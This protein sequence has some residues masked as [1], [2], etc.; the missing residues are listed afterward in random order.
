MCLHI[1][2]EVIKDK[3]YRPKNND[4]TITNKGK[5][6]HENKVENLI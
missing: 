6:N 5:I 2:I 4:K 3:K 1:L